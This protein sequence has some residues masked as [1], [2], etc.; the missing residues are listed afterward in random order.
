MSLKCVQKKEYT[1]FYYHIKT[2]DY[3]L[4][5]CSEKKYT[6]LYSHIKTL[7]YEL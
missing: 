6:N 5:M 2:L 7:E 1:N 3:E 4:K